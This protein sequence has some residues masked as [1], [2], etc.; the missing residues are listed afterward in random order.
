MNQFCPICNKY[1]SKRNPRV[2][3]HLKYSNPE[4][5]EFTCRN[6]NL[7]EFYYRNPDKLKSKSIFWQWWWKRRIYRVMKYYENKRSML[8]TFTENRTPQ[9]I[10]I[11]NKLRSLTRDQ[12][13]E[14]LEKHNI[15]FKPE[16][17]EEIK[18]SESIDVIVMIPIFDIPLDE[19]ENTLKSY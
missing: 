5:T 15:K 12:I 1:Y 3:A 18:K 13:L 2:N 19:L 9:E 7:A 4:E 11:E 8:K 14:I 17:L 16:V 6:C 10:K